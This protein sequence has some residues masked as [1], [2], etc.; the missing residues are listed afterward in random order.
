MHEL[1]YWKYIVGA[2]PSNAL[3]KLLQIPELESLSPCLC[4]IVSILGASAT[5]WE[6]TASH[7]MLH[8]GILKAMIDRLDALQ[9]AK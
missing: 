9:I 4:S 3:G 2:Q 8:W 7:Y 1:W 6:L 5:V